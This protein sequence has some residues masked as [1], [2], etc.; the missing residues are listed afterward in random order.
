[1]RLKAC[2]MLNMHLHF[3][4]YMNL[5]LAFT[6]CPSCFLGWR[7]TFW[8]RKTRFTDAQPFSASYH[9]ESPAESDPLVPLVPVAPLETW[10]FPV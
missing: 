5:R 9:R 7:N 8:L 10:V 2:K 4:C 1:M 6:L 3:K